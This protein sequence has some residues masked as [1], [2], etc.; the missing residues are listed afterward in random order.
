MSDMAWQA[1]FDFYNVHDHNFADEP[2]YITSDAIKQATTKFTATRDREPRLLCK[3]D[4]RESRP[5]LFKDRDLFLLPVKNGEYA[6]LR[7]E[8]YIDIPP[9]TSALQT[10]T[11]LLDFELDT[12]KVGNSEMQH[13]DYAYATSLIRSVMDDDSLVLTIRGQKYT[14]QFDVH[15]G[16]TVL[17][18]KSVQTEVDAGYEGRNQVVLLKTLFP[19]VSN[20]P[21]YPLFLAHRLYTST[22]DKAVKVIL[23]ELLGHCFGLWQVTFSDKDNL[24]SCKVK[25]LGCWLLKSN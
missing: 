7:G 22:T 2:F 24:K 4:T 16:S 23:L 13:V 15:I 20:T 11:S 14:P 12:V 19:F 10:Y 17:K 3:H 21:I 6:I 1:I 8:G 5:Q 9:I 18:T 25:A